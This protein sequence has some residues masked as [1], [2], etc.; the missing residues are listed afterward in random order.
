MSFDGALARLKGHNPRRLRRGSYCDA[1]GTCC[2]IGVLSPSARRLGPL[3]D[4]TGIGR[5]WDRDAAVRAELEAHGLARHEAV[6]LQ[7]LNDMTAPVGLSDEERHAF[8]VG[9]LEQ[10]I[11]KQAALAKAQEVFR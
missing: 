7:A 6:T 8:V 11:A 10:Y 3:G 4:T 9:A 1:Q 5:L 2:A